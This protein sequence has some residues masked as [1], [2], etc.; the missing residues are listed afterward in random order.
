MDMGQ[1]SRQKLE[2]IEIHDFS[3]EAEC[4]G[5]Q[6]SASPGGSSR[7]P[8]WQSP[9]VAVC[10]VMQATRQAPT[11]SH[12]YQYVQSKGVLMDATLNRRSDVHAS[13]GSR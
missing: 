5:A 8:V 2:A 11:L 4:I 13:G 10:E 3:R 9:S 1:I 12:R 7:W 6:E